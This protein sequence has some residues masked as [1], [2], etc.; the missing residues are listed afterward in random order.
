MALTVYDLRFGRLPNVLTLPG[1]A[2]ILIGATAQLQGLQALA[3]ALA[4]AA[5]YLMIHLA[6]PRGMGAGDVKLAIGLGGWTGAAGVEQWVVAAVGAPLLTVV[7][8]AVLRRRQLP[9]G[10]AM[11]TASA[12]AVLLVG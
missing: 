1:A 5:T 6:A 9:H 2:T 10:P 8:A 7:A 12:L 11:C 3:G 4:L